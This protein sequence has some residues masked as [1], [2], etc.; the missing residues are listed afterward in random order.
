MTEPFQSIEPAPRQPWSAELKTLLRLA[1]P[2]AVVQVGLSLMSFVDTA[3]AGHMS[4]TALAATGLG[5]SVFFLVAIMGLGVVLGLDPLASQAFGA[6]EPRRARAAMWQGVWTALIVSLPLSLVMLVLATQLE[7]F[8]VL[9]EIA[10]LGREYLLAR[11]PSLFP[12]LAFVA[13][14][15]Y[16][17]SA[18][19]TGAVVLSTVI[20]NVLN[21]VADWVLGF[22]D[23]GL[24]ELGLPAVGLPALGVAG[25]A[26]ASTVCTVGQVLILVAAVARVPVPQA[27]GEGSLRAPDRAVILGI[28][29]LGVP[30]GLMLLA[31][32]GVFSLAQVLIAG[33]SVVSAAA[34]QAALRF[35]SLTFSMCLGVGAATSGEVGRAIGR[36]DGPATRRAG[37]LGMLIGLGFMSCTGLVMAIFPEPLAR[38]MGAG[39]E[40]L[41]LTVTLLRIAALFQLADG[42]Q[43]VAGGALRG[44]GTTHWAS[45]ANLLAHWGFG[46]PV[47][48]ALAYAAGLGAVGLWWGFVLG[49]GAVALAFSWK[50]LR[51]ARGD[52]RHL[53]VQRS[54]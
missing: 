41:P 39:P 16:L 51:V 4:S 9:P 53:R 5:G 21:L 8:G 3:V 54:S 12:M 11:I 45:V 47:G 40:S 22:G 2:L 1:G 31:E 24:V 25:L 27:E 49:L 38:L 43:A 30:I 46:L 26:W 15:S 33:M 52:V 32:I 7:R 13:L 48:L 42:L 14:R 10:A 19:L 35:A 28:L 23:A 34:H 50:F 36:E 17:Q 6:G 20:A 37:I 18:H 29:R 44:A